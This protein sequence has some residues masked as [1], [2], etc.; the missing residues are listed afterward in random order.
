MV[1]KRFLH[2]LAYA[3]LVLLA[4][5][6]FFPFYYVFVL[7][8]WPDSSMFVIPPHI[9]FGNA[10]IQNLKHLFAQV[11]FLRNMFNSF[12]IAVISTAT[13]IFFCTMGG[14]AFALYSFRGKNFLF[15][16]MLVTYMIPGSLSIVPFFKIIKAFGWYNTWLPLIVP[17]MSNAFGIFLMTQYIRSSV[18]RDLLD[19]AR[20]DGMGE[21]RILIRVIFPLSKSGVSVL[22]ILTFIGSWNTFLYAYL[23]LPSR[24]WTT[25]PVALATLFSKATGGYGAIMVGNA[26]A[27][28]PLTVVLFIFSKQIISGIAEGGLKG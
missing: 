15:S 17:G 5:L 12:S 25:F 16:F 4:V 26:I 2:T 24:K 3:I 20:I 7:A 14:A 23:M 28:L 27:L 8:S 19:A 21:F 13:E 9:L 22:G 18:H 10:F 1:K 11:N 6:F